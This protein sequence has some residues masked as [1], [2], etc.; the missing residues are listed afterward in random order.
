[1]KKQKPKNRI[2]GFLND[3]F[4]ADTLELDKA[5]FLRMVK[6]VNTM[7]STFSKAVKRAYEAGL[8]HG[9]MLG[10]AIAVLV[11]SVAIFIGD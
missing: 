1:M 10:L 2:K 5:Q 7:H 8:V 4:E 3:T 9:L 6:T 11:M